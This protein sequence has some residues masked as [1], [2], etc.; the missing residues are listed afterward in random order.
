MESARGR[1]VTPSE[2]AVAALGELGGPLP[3]HPS[4]PQD[5]LALLDRVAA[6]ATVTS[7][8]GRSFGCSDVTRAVID[9]VQR[10]GTCWCGGT[11]WQGR[12]AMR[13]SVSSWATTSQDVDVSI[14]AMVRAAESSVR[15][16]P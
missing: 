12:A 9:A 15:I 16:A 4:A 13:I 14:D 1:R 2:A 6:P 10:D 3:E 7:N 5:V 11:E 8:G